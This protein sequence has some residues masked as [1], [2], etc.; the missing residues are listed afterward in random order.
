MRVNISVKLV[1]AV[2]GRRTRDKVGNAK[3]VAAVKAVEKRRTKAVSVRG[4]NVVNIAAKV[5]GK[6]IPGVG[7]LEARSDIP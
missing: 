4:V 3:A 5:A 2:A 1:S 6:R 7:S